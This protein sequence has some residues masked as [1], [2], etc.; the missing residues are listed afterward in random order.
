MWMSLLSKFSVPTSRLLNDAEEKSSHNQVEYHE[1]NIMAS[2]TN[3]V[4]TLTDFLHNF[5]IQLS[6]SAH[7]GYF[8]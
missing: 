7:S 8:K 1:H 2:D 6:S 4:L 3:G 5:H